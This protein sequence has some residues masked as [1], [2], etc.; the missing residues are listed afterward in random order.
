M[1]IAGGADR[2]GTRVI[3]WNMHKGLN[4]QWE[5][6]YWTSTTTTTTV[7]TTFEWR[8]GRPFTIVNQMH[9]K[10]LLTLRGGNFVIADRDN[11]ANQLFT[12]NAET[13]TI[14][15]YAN[16]GRALSI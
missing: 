3:V 2:D 14:N 11:S 9:H 5:I 7:T 6:V 4:Q 1:D 12:F 13:K 15:A 10:R 16:Q 8:V